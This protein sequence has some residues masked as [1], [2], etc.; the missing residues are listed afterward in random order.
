MNAA[1]RHDPVHGIWSRVCEKCFKG[2]EGYSDTEGI[3]LSFLIARN[4]NNTHTM[5]LGATRDWT[6]AFKTHRR[7][8]IERALLDFNLLEKRI[9]RVWFFVAKYILFNLN[10]K[11]FVACM[12][13]K[14]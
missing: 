10:I 8:R 12:P 13:R 2:R 7:D 9:D 6:D 1:A 4:R 14:W 11:S 3:F 5:H